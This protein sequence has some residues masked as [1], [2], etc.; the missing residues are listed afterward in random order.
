MTGVKCIG[1]FGKWIL[2]ASSTAFLLTGCAR[3]GQQFKAQ[4]VVTAYEAEHYNKNLYTGKLFASD[5]CV[6]SENVAF[7]GAPD[8]AGLHAAGLFDVEDGMVDFAYNLHDRL[9]PASTTKIMTALV[10]L[11]KGNL[12]DVVTVQADADAANFAADEKTCG[13]KAGDQMTLGDLLHGLLMES[14]N[15]AAVAIADYIGGN[16]EQ[17]AQMMN[18]EAQA[19]MATK[20]HFLNSNGLHNEN[21]YTTAYDLYLIFNEC[22]KYD[23]FVDIINTAEYT[24]N[25][26]GADKTVHQAAWKQ[27]NF[28]ALGEAEL[29]QSA[30]IIG[31]KT[32]TTELAGNCLILLEK[33]ASGRPYIS[34]VMGADTKSLLY[35]DMTAIINGIGQQ[36]PAAADAA[37]GDAKQD[38]PAAASDVDNGNP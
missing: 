9:Y 17:F 1:R 6:A 3:I 5:L 30:T 7:Q 25:I 35:Q 32:G 28:Y 4:E 12:T 8:P 29:P 20:T 33:D 11:K 34:I 10:A 37:D 23:E 21:H 24:A 16:S 27:T 31:G 19:L 14:G 13:I 36:E 2:M 38:E 15:D 26:T 18:E 22:I